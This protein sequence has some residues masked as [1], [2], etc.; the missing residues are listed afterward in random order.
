MRFGLATALLLLATPASAQTPGYRDAARTPDA[1][2]RDLLARMTLE[3]KFRQLFMVPGELGGDSSRYAAGLFG[4]QPAARGDAAGEAT[5]LLARDASGSARRVAERMNATQRWFLERTRLGIPIIPF[6]EGLHGVVQDG[7]TVFPQAIALAATFDTALMTRV[8]TAIAAEARSRGIRQLLSPVVN[9]VTDVRWGRVEETYGED[10]WLTS[11]MGEAYVRAV[12]RAGVIATPKHFAANIGDGGRDSYPVQWDDRFLEEVI[13]PPFRAAVAAG[14]RSVM[15]SYNSVRGEPATASRF[16]LTETLRDRW[17]FPG[18]VVAD[19]GGTGGS[20]VLHLTARDYPDATR[21]AIPAGLDVIFQTDLAHEPLFLPAFTDGRVPAA[22]LDSA[23][24]R[25]L[26]VK[27]A[28]GLFDDPYVDPADAARINGAPAHRALALEA[29]RKSLVLLQNA[30]GT[31]PLD[32][33]AIRSLAVIGPDAVEARLGGYSGRGNAPVSILDGILAAAK[34]ITVR[35]ATGPGRSAALFAPIPASA[36]RPVAGADSARGLTAEYFPTI[37]LSGAARTVRR[38]ERVAFSWTLFGP[39]GLPNDW[40]S[41]RWRGTL[42]APTTGPLTVGIEGSDGYRLRI[43]GKVVLDAWYKRSSGRRT[44]TLPTVR[45][46]RHAIELEYYETTGNGRIALV[47]NHGV[48][49]DADAK[50]AEAV[51]VA[52]SSDAAVIVAGIEEGEFRDRASLALPG[53]Q[54]E[55]IRRVAATGKPVTVVLIGGSAVTMRSWLDRVGAVLQAWYPGEAGGTAVGEA[56][57]GDV[58]PA[59]RLPFTVPL[60]EAQLPLPYFH[61]P[62]GRGDDYAD[63]VGE[64]LFPFGHGLS[65]T[66]FRYDSL[67]VVAAGTGRWSV[68]VSVTNT[69]R[70]SG[71]EVVQL[72]LR[73]RF[74]SVARPN[75]LLKG[76]ERITLAPGEARRVLFTVGPEE[77]AFPDRDAKWVTEPTAVD[78]MVGSSS[79]E[80]RVRGAVPRP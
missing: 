53:R 37:D 67:S 14:A 28:L 23:A 46:R 18:F 32:R 47:W 61:L 33:G 58:N 4:L 78:V 30:K 57:F 49:N 72:Y 60:A 59:G 42:V 77:L 43:D 13:F 74:A 70:R 26:R 66:T 9:V 6:E 19:A 1:R 35:H 48:A 62:T 38:D 75:L 29:A 25:V 22:A 41:V 8:A 16:L 51:R 7:A 24:L 69:G 17:R 12:E 5:Q 20:V 45:G 52:A 27:F 39:H 44:V 40:Y 68:A 79:R 31:L 10:P 21:L 3:E 54:E 71:D 64:P 50:I 11:R 2:A 73:Q 15:A 76:M 80:I 63:L 56:L 34:G 36:L 55:L 65:Y